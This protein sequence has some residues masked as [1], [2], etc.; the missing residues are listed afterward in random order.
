MKTEYNGLILYE[1]DKKKNSNVTCRL[2]FAI[3]QSNTVNYITI[4]V[5]E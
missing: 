1:Y 4:R 3:D 5:L 2:R